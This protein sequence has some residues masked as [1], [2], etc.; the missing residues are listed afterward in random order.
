MITGAFLFYVAIRTVGVASRR[1]CIAFPAGA[2]GL[3]GFFRER[4]THP[5]IWSAAI[6]LLV[7]FLAM[8]VK[9]AAPLRRRGLILS[10]IPLK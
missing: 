7:A 10:V 5:H 8:R 9:P 6:L 4:L 2:L 3:S 1:P